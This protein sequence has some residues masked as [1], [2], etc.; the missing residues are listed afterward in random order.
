[1]LNDNAKCQS[2]REWTGK[3]ENEQKTQRLCQSKDIIAHSY[4][5]A[6]NAVRARIVF[7]L[8]IYIE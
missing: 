1:M 8:E 6:F 5:L 3:K 7:A 4:S 2:G